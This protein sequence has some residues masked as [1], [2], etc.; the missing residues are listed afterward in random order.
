MAGLIAE[1]NEKVHWA[2]I[3]LTET[4]HE[5]PSQSPAR[6]TQSRAIIT[7]PMEELAKGIDSHTKAGNKKESFEIASKSTTIESK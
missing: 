1:F 6:I 7:T 3:R 5:A 4:K 2:D